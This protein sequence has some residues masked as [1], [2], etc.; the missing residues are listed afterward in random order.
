MAN[1]VRRLAI[2]G[3]GYV[4]GAVARAAL[5][6]GWPVTALTRNPATAA[7]LDKMGARALVAELAEASWHEQMAGEFDFVLNSVGSGGGAPGDY[8]RSYVDGMQSIARWL[9]QRAGR[10]P[11]F[12]YTSS[13]SVYAKSA[14]G[15]VTEATAP[16]ADSAST[17]A[18]LEAEQMVQR[19]VAPYC[20]RWYV[21]RLAGIYG[22]G[23]HRLLD[24]ARTGAWHSAP[25]PERAINLV[26]RDDI[27]RAIM[28]CFEAE[29]GSGGIYN[30]ADGSP[31]TRGQILAWL[32]QRLGQ[33]APALPP[34]GE[35]AAVRRIDCAKLRHALG[36]APRHPD[37]RSG[38]EEILRQA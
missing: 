31:A 5:A 16:A 27:V 15:A 3:C 21:L 19:Q 13:T 32:A 12:V 2:F 7:G 8:R 17:A 23:R 29:G 11:V 28:A 14:T 4:G 6:R 30:V 25:E 18:L 20:A 26:H 24:L 37:F 34:A 33:A 1:L 9:A 22:P 35:A 38:Y 10:K 36:W